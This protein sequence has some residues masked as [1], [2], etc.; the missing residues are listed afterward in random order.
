MKRLQQADRIHP[1]QEG[2]LQAAT[3][4]V[5]YQDY[6]DESH[7]RLDALLA[8]LQADPMAPRPENG[9]ATTGKHNP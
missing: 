4:L 6:W 5:R 1:P 9:G 8:R 3:W 2:L 7:A